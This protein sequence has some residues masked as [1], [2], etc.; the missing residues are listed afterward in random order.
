MVNVKRYKPAVPKN[1]LF[2][3]AGCV[4]MAVGI[5]LLFLAYTWL[6]T[7]VGVNIW[8]LA[9]GGFL[10]GLMVHHFGFLKIVDKNLDRI[11]PMEDKQCLFSF[12]PWKSYLIIAIM[13]TMG[14]M[15]RH[16]SVPKP[17]LAVLYMGIGLALSLSSIRYIRIFIREVRK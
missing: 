6:R 13:V 17:Y 7:A 5:M 10:L 8:Y 1:S 4:W 11:L 9:A 12:F 14:K 3:L 2:F 15:L 16:S